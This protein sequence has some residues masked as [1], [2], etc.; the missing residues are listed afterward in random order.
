M[1]N[2]FTRCQAGFP[3]TEGRFAVIAPPSVRDQ[4]E[5][6]IHEPEAPPGATSLSPP[7]ASNLLDEICR[8]IV[9][10]CFPEGHF[11][12]AVLDE[13][14]LAGAGRRAAYR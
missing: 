11:H 8:P 9:G 10:C 13:W 6:L 4:T 5:P 7:L 14:S 2:H 3:H 12:D 1:G